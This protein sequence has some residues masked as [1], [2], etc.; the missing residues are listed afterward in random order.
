MLWL[1]SAAAALSPSGG[2]QVGVGMNGLQAV[3]QSFE[4][5]L[6]NQIRNLTL[7]DIKKKESGFDVKLY[8]MR[9]E[10]FK[11]DSPCIVPTFGTGGV[12]GIELPGFRLKFHI[13]AE[14]KK[15]ILKVSTVCD[16][17]IGT[18]KLSASAAIQ[19]SGG[20]L[21]LGSVKSSADVGHF[22]PNCGGG[23]S[24][25]VINLI[26]SLF[27]STIKDELNEL[28]EQEVQ[29]ALKEEAK[30]LLSEITWKY[31]LEKGIAILDYSP[32]ALTST[33][34]H[35]SMNVQASLVDASGDLPPAATM[36]ALPSWSPDAG[37]AYLQTLLSAWSLDTVAFTYWKAKRLQRHI[38]HDDIGQYSP[39][40]L[41]T[42]NIGVLCAP[43]L[44]VKYPHHWMTIDSAFSS[45]PVTTITKSGVTAEAPATFAFSVVNSTGGIVDSAF[46]V[47]GNVTLG[48]TFN[49][50]SDGSQTKQ[51][52][53]AEITQ[54]TLPLTVLRSDVGNV[55][56]KALS[57]VVNAA[58]EKLLI[59]LANRVLH[60]GVPLPST[61]MVTLENTTLTPDDGYLLV[62]TK[63]KVK[64]LM[65]AR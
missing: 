34:D 65:S 54:A 63:F 58:V 60:V 47:G 23:V 33:T 8:N 1:V 45:S 12:I 53:T 35:L 51:N 42:S 41:N 32:Q 22:D 3:V 13:R 9:V 5:Y 38:T 64:P 24:G 17:K 56:V 30:Q 62:A 4:P 61:P 52:L 40:Q 15:S 18:A 16:S 57:A 6:L 28:I 19:V 7:K 46:T 43:G 11:C 26:S 2:G 50:H 20:Q 31:T 27:D 37:D 36:P 21:S 25:S 49:I 10:D 44:L 48:V 55:N 29:S 14:A 59:P 39:V